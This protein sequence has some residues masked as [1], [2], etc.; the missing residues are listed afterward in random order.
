MQRIIYPT[1]EGGIAVLVCHKADGTPMSPQ[2]LAE[3]ARKDV[4][5]G[6]PFRLVDAADIPEDRSQRTLWTADF[7]TPDGY[8]VGAEAWFAEQAVL[9]EQAVQEGQ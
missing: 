2:P 4:P 3:I 1:A 8:G 9:A 5:A 6:V 7:S